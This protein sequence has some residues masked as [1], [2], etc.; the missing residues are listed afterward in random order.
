MYLSY[1]SLK[2]IHY[3]F[4]FNDLL[5][6]TQCAWGY[7]LRYTYG[8]FRQEIFQGW[9]AEI[10]DNWLKHG[11]PWEIIRFDVK[12]AVR[13]YGEAMG[14]VWEGTFYD[15]YRSAYL[16]DPIQPNICSLIFFLSFIFVLCFFRR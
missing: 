8:M 12:Y 2:R 9:Q 11:N 5:S 1:L 10:P 6:L 14:N 4:R 13:F 3:L 7:G 16:P 15:L